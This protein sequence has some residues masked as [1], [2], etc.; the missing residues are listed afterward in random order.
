[1]AVVMGRRLLTESS[2]Q[3]GRGGGGHGEEASD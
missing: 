1:M 2:A 3:V